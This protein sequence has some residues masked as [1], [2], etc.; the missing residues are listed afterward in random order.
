MSFVTFVLGGA[1][2]GKSRYAERL[3]AQHRGHKT[4]IATAEGVDSEMQARIA[5]HRSRRGENWETLDAPLDLVT[6]LRGCQTGFVLIDCITVWIGNLMHH[7]R[8]VRVEV[9]KLCEALADTRTRAVVVSNEVGLAIV[10]DNALARAFR[11]EQGFANQRIAEVADEVVFL[12]AGLPMVL[13]KTR[14][15]P[16]SKAKAKS[17]RGRRT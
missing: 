4:Y 8:D 10:P 17:S 5:E 1:R 7:K 2:S 12:V 14:R 15:K 11:D 3:A 16:A 9:E 13:K 6:A